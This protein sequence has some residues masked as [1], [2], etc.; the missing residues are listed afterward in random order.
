MNDDVGDYW[1]PHG[2]GYRHVTKAGIDWH[3]SREHQEEQG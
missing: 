3:V 1:C 2:C